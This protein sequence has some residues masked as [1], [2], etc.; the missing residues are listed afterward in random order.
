M[1]VALIVRMHSDRRIAEHGLRSCR[2][3][4]D[5]F[6]GLLPGIIDDTGNHLTVAMFL[7]EKAGGSDVGANESVAVRDD[8]IDRTAE[9]VAVFGRGLVRMPV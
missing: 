6:A 1:F 4:H 9:L 8:D 2:R 3:D 7:T 5:K